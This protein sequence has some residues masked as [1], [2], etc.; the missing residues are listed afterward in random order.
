MW[1]SLAVATGSECCISGYVEVHCA[2]IDNFAYMWE[3]L[4]SISDLIRNGRETG[5]DADIMHVG[6]VRRE[7]DRKVVIWQG[8]TLEG[9]GSGNELGG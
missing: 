9:Y 6:K 1:H 2:A 4:K 7:R 8:D 5:N 3:P